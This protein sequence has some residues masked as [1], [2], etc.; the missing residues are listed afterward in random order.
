MSQ[1]IAKDPR[2][3]RDVMG[4]FA[5]GVTVLTLNV[6]NELRGMTANAVTSLS[7]EPMLLLACVDRKSSTHA[8]FEQADAF[9]V[10]ILEAGQRPL[11]ELFARHGTP[12]EPMGGAAYR[13]GVLDVPVLDGALA[14]AECRVRE[15]YEGGDHTNRDRGGRRHGR[16]APRRRAAGVLLRRLPAPAG[17]ELA[18]RAASPAAPGLRHPRRGCGV[19]PMLPRGLD[20]IG[21]S[22][23][24]SARGGPVPID[25]LGSQPA[26]A[27]AP[28]AASAAS[29]AAAAGAPGAPALD[30][31]ALLQQKLAAPHAQ[32]QQVRAEV[33][34]LR[35]GGAL[36]AAVRSAALG[37]AP[38][39]PSSAAS[40]GFAAAADSAA[41]SLATSRLLALRQ[42]A[43][44]GP[45]PYGWRAMATSIGDSVVGPGF[46][47]LFERQINQ[48]SGFSPDVA[49]GAR[50]SSAG[51]EG[52][53]QLMPQYYPG[54]D[55]TDPQ[56]SL[57]AA[58]Q[59]MRHYLEAWDGDVRKALASYNAGLGR[60]RQ[61]VQAHG[62]AWE[63][64][65]PA[66]TRQYL[67][68]IVGS[69]DYTVSLPAGGSAAVFGGVGPGG[70]LTSPVDRV[71]QQQLLGRVL[72]MIASTGAGVRAPSDG[73]VTAVRPG[74]DGTL[75]I[76]LDNGNGWTTL[77]QGLAAANV[78][79][80]DSVRR[81]DLLG[82]L[83][84]SAGGSGALDLGV[85]L[86]GQ[87]VDPSR[88]LLAAQLAQLAHS[89]SG[90]SGT[91]AALP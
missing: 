60:V 11:S 84:G 25:A 85:Q 17:A 2:L 63:S 37:G 59:T 12:P 48:E 14:Y 61:A 34:S 29:A 23:I 62:D 77:L 57:T 64:A 10:N 47:A 20:S 81:S 69:Q 76:T 24:R 67:Q 46:G 26:G 8:M 31:A 40:T 18:P 70:V 21:L 49:L 19:F 6:D 16:R 72:Q 30:F 42:T 91:G 80:G 33:A 82:T 78:A 71:Q 53:A 32:I 51:A 35:N 52:I 79:P 55:R 13:L 86:D 88:Y 15:R 73:M 45:D 4:R 9:G 22:G 50:T 27:P 38:A 54:V 75:G 68:S 39:T 43:S 44:A 89:G 74:A 90:G 87:A 66:E 3:F 5:T 7:L 36:R 58:A 41:P 1:Q 83:A 56:Q 65:L 28:A